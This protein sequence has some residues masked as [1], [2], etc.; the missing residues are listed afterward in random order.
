MSGTQTTV[1]SPA[2]QTWLIGDSSFGGFST[3]S[4]TLGYQVYTNAGTGMEMKLGKNP[5][6]KDI[7]AS[8]YIKFVKSKLGKVQIER[9]KKRLSKLQKLVAYSKEMGQQALYEELTK[10]VAVLVCE[11]ELVAF[12]IDKWVEFKHIDKFR[13]VVKEK[14]IKWEPL[15][16]FPRVVPRKVQLKVKALQKA[17]IFDEFWILFIDY[18]KSE[19]L[20]TNKEKIRNKDPILFGRFKYQP[21]KYYYIADWVDEF[22][23]LT[24]DK[25]V[26]KIKLEDKEFALGEIEDIDEDRWDNIVK[27]V[28]TRVE[29]YQA[30]DSTSYRRLMAEEDEL[31]NGKPKRK[32][33]KPWTWRN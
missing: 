2:G 32:W 15:E 9:V 12:G 31:R 27:E 6:T 13:N 25:F 18:T 16:K 3:G 11:S 28:K 10:E 19:P 33:Y 4:T 30:A 5:V 24:L 23:D 26:D 17:N 7:S 21:D 1:T 22:C 29:R 20:K 14:V 8:L